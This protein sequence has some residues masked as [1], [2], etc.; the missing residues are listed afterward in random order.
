MGVGSGSG[1]IDL[2]ILKVLHEKHPD[3]N[4]VNEVVEPSKPMLNKYKALLSKTPGLDYVTFR[5]NK[6]TATEFRTEWDKRNGNKMHF[7]N[8]IQMLCYVDDM[9]STLSFYR[10]L[11]HKDGKI[12][13]ILAR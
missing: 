7:I 10:S 2:E 4:V 6:M 8:M 11:L 13:V 1:E 12:L 3:A 5:W 9:E